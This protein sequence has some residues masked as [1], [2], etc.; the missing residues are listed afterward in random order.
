M[1]TLQQMYQSICRVIN[2]RWEPAELKDG[3]HGHVSCALLVAVSIAGAA[4]HRAHVRLEIHSDPLCR[5]LKNQN[6]SELV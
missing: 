4:L 1:D 6:R 5:S 2:P 3:W